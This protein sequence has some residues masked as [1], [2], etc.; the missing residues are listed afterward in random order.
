MPLN[1]STN[2][3]DFLP[4]LKYNAK[5]GRWYARPEGSD[6]DVE[7]T[8]LKAVFDLENIQTGWLHFGPNGP[9]WQPDESLAKSGA[10]PSQDHKRGFKIHVHSPKQLGG[11]RELMSS[12]MMMN[13]AINA[14]YSAW[15]QGGKKQCPVVSCTG[16]TPITGKHGTNYEPILAIDKLVDRP[17]DMAILGGGSAP[18]Q[19]ATPEPEAPALD[20]DDEF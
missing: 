6:D 8:N 1:L 2:S 13:G 10:A 15:E 20:E 19:A 7:V 18:A 11:T 14:L 3:G 17:A 5:A 16:T 12:S 9:D 4:I